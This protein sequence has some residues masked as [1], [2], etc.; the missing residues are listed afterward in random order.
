MQGNSSAD[1]SPLAH[2]LRCQLLG[3]EV[4][5]P[6]EVAGVGEVSPFL[7]VMLFFT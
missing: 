2:A 7:A 3:L 4:F 6:V 1:F 5:L